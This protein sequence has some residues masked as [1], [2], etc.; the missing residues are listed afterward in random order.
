MLYLSSFHFRDVAM[1]IIKSNQWD[2]ALRNS[3][4]S[5]TPLRKM[6][7]KM[8]GLYCRLGAVSMQFVCS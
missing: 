4:G 7:Q 5:E 2:Q 6:I 1:T 3:C 8:P